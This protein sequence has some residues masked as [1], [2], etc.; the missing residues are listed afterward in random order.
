M[1]ELYIL[2]QYDVDKPVGNAVSQMSAAPR[3]IG[4]TLSD[5]W[6]AWVR[7]VM[8]NA[9]WL[10]CCLTIVLLPPATF[11]MYHAAAELVMGRS[12][13]WSEFLTGARR[14]FLKSW[15]WMLINGVVAALLWAKVQ[16]YSQLGEAWA[17][18]LRLIAL[19]LGACWLVVQFY[20]LPYFMIQQQKRLRVALK[21]G[22]LTALASPL[23]SLVLSLFVALLLMASLYFPVLIFVGVPAMI[24]VLGSHAVRERL[25]TFGKIGEQP[26]EDDTL[27]DAQL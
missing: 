4:R 27:E 6:F 18:V 17:E 22:L 8:I 11:G 13:A 21:N 9:T 7:L 24:A 3:V 2:L 23:Y 1:S 19:T 5:W 16:F 15:L 26:S 12:M 14:Y 20:A 10:A 25:E